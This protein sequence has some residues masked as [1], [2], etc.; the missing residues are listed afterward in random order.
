MNSQLWPLT[1]ATAVAR[2]RER[3]ASIRAFMSTRCDAAARE[4]AESAA[5]T[6]PLAGV[7]Y[8]LKDEW[9]TAGIPTTGG[10][11]RHR[12]RVPN[13]DCAL[14]EVLRSAGAVLVGKSNLSDMG[15]APEANNYLVGGTRNPYD[16]TRTAGGSSGG[17]AA[18]V[19]DGMAAF[20]W[21]TDIG[22]SIRM[23]A[24]F[25][26]VFG[27]RLSSATWPIRDLF[28]SLPE[29]LAWMCGQ[30]PITRSL[31]QMTELLDVTAP[32]LRTGPRQAFQPSKALI[33][34]PSHLG[35]WPT[36]TQDVTPHAAAVFGGVEDAAAHLPS[37]AKLARVYA[38]LWSSHLE[39]LT[40]ADE[41]LTLAEGLAA[42]FSALLLRGRFGDRRFH[43]DM[44]K[45]LG[46]MAIGRVT[47]YRDTQR[48]LRNAAAIRERMIA[49]WERG[50]VV[51]APVCMYPAPRLGKSTNNMH[52]LD[53]TIS[54]NIA[55][56]TSLAIPFGRFADGLPRAIQLMGP[57]GSEKVLLN[58]AERWV[59]AVVA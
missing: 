50:Y 32:R 20:D 17:A 1:V 21:G 54:G 14:Y 51:V 38:S 5:A 22:G 52:L 12:D 44:A 56:A 4:A 42:T 53:C 33:Y 2:I 39:Q 47:F 35:L 55:D 48:A 15:L 19:A 3:D 58:L 40:A 26:G 41:T 24:G 16:L 10:S 11:Y 9:D 37:T 59:S 29:P 34:A 25:C 7:P 27:L 45:L 23:P 36:F 57:P 8:S 49:A 28:P 18:A 46:L 6:G 43:P 13:K 30:G 31:A